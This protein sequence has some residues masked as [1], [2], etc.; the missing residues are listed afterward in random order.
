MGAVA[1]RLAT[2][3]DVA[4]LPAIEAA[5]GEQFRTVPGL[6][7]VADHDP[8]FAPEFIDVAV[9]QDRVWVAEV[10]GAL[11]GYALGLDLGGQPHLEQVSVL[12]G[13]QGTGIGRALIDQVSTWAAAVGGTSLTLATFHDVPW[14]AP[15]YAH[16]GF[17]PIPEDEVLADADLLAVRADEGTHG[18][19]PDT[20]VFMRRPV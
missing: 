10:D 8:S 16:L 11:V 1:V 18:L 7:F 5:A 12:P 15:F 4:Q 2:A 20:R 17:V 14:N 3:D 19:D 13:H 6:A 9:A